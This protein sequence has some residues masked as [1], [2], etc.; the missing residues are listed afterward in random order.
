M[1]S[2]VEILTSLTFVAG[3]SYVFYGIILSYHW[4]RYSESWTIAAFSLGSYMIGGVYLLGLMVAAI[5]ML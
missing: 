3:A 5:V 4:I 1:I 2:T